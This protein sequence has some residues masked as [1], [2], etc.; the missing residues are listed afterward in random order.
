M[1]ILVVSDEED[2]ALWNSFQPEK[3]SGI[4]LAISCGDLDPE[5]LSFIVTMLQAPLFYVHG[6]HDENY[7]KRPPEGCESIDGRI[8]HYQGL[9]ILGL[10]GSRRY[11][12][13]LFQYT[14]RQMKW[15]IRK[16]QISLSLWKGVDLL[17]T[18][19]PSKGVGDGTDLCHRG[20]ESFNY[21]I[22]KYSPRYHFHGHQHLYYNAYNNRARTR[23]NRN[24]SVVNACGKMFLEL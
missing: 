24:T 2:P 11:R 17:V 13:G 3:F 15:R 16:L 23:Q 1:K 20:F 7:V 4:D 21:L 6:N 19:A 10:G 12:E 14:E 22:K 18:H 9:R 5:Y 8:V